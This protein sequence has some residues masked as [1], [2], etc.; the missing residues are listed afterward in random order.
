MEFTNWPFEF[1]FS[2]SQA[3]NNPWKDVQA[4]DYVSYRFWM[5][6]AAVI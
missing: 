3:I 2:G 6:N 5:F 4:P 1:V